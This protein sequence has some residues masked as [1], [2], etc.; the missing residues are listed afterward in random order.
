MLM[1]Q[2]IHWRNKHLN[3][4]EKVR[5]NENPDNASDL[6]HVESIHEYIYNTELV[7]KQKVLA[8]LEKLILLKEQT[9]NVKKK[10]NFTKWCS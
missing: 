6:W 8:F 7:K 1:L 3:E 10:H 5:W 4:S 9:A 2:I